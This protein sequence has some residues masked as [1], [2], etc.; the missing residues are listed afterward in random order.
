MFQLKN[1]VR[2]NSFHKNNFMTI[3][4]CSLVVGSIIYIVYITSRHKTLT[5]SWANAGPPSTMLG[6]H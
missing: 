4:R 5:Q 6:Q 2:L 3:Y 1:N